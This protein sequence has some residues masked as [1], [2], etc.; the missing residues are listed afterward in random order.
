MGVGAAFLQRAF[1]LFDRSGY[2]QGSGACTSIG[3]SVHLREELKKLYWKEDK[4][5]VGGKTFW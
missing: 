4:T 1:E 5:A 3:T 2:P